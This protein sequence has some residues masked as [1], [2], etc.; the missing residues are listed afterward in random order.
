MSVSI[1][2]LIYWLFD[3]MLDILIDWLI[4]WL[5]LIDYVHRYLFSYIFRSGFTESSGPSDPTPPLHQT[6]CRGSLCR[7]WARFQRQPRL[8]R[9]IVYHHAAGFGAG[10]FRRGGHCEFHWSAVH[11]N[12]TVRVR[13]SHAGQGR[14]RVERHHSGMRRRGTAEIRVLPE[15]SSPGASVGVGPIG[16]GPVWHAG[17]DGQQRENC[18]DGSTTGEFCTRHGG[19]WGFDDFVHRVRLW[20]QQC[21][22]CGSGESF[23]Y[24]K[25]NKNSRETYWS[26]IDWNQSI[27]QSI[28]HS[29][30][31]VSKIEINQS[32]NH[33]NKYECK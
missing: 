18:A 32:I 2:W 17:G 9:C 4:D 22:V 29:N 1:D 8:I 19:V 30:I 5:I 20:W 23:L 14:D 25:A 31:N 10:S 21:H 6:W 3:W 26:G 12:G 11:E 7:H 16:S 15:K 24:K 13:G 33:S 28:N 27:N